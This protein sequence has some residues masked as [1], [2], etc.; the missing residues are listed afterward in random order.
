MMKFLDYLI[1]SLGLLV[2]VFAGSV[3]VFAQ[4]N[5][6][7]TIDTFHA[8]GLIA[9]MIGLQG[10]NQSLVLGGDWALA[11]IDGNVTGLYSD[12][13]MTDT[14]GNTRHYMSFSNFRSN[15]TSV[16]LNPNGVTT[17]SGTVDLRESFNPVLEDVNIT[18]DILNGNIIRVSTTDE[19]VR[20]TE[21]FQDQPIYGTIDSLRDDINNVQLVEGPR[22]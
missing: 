16:Q 6:T 17:I 4:T 5:N 12:F 9:S 2:S 20:I 22:P 1:L 13:T 14:A 21:H 18:L 11:V 19:R 7:S 8:N 10:S 3:P 15:D